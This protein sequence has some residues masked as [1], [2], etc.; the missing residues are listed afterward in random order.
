LVETLRRNLRPEIRHELLNVSVDS[1]AKLRGVCRR[2]ES[3]LEDV[4]R[5]YGYQ[6]PAPFRRRV[7][8]L[9][10]E[11]LGEDATEFSDGELIVE[12]DA[13]ALVCWN[14]RLWR[15]EENL[16]VWLWSSKYL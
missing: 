13:L 7:S 3:F 10:Q 8:E 15:K 9:V 6:N 12:V 2:R 11:S 5:S 1:V 14:C 16:L 4:R